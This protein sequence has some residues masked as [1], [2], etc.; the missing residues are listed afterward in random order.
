MPGAEMPGAQMPKLRFVCLAIHCFL[1]NQT[2]QV[3]AG[4]S[5]QTC[6]LSGHTTMLPGIRLTHSHRRPHKDKRRNK[7][8]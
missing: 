7:S 5:S 2:A 6:H 4:H 1:F 3:K 8:A